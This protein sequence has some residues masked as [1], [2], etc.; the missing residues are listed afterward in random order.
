MATHEIPTHLEVQDKLVFG[1]TARQA[2]AIG[3]GLC[4]GYVIYQQTHIRLLGYGPWA[5]PLVMRI[6]SGI[7]GAGLGVL[8]AFVRPLNRPLETWVLVYVRYAT[9]PKCTR[10][11]PVLGGHPS[12]DDAELSAL[13]VD[14][15]GPVDEECAPPQSAWVGH[16]AATYAEVLAGD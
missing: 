6:S 7:F 5:V 10:W 14:L 2:L 4:L 15:A 13:I 9:M 8:V 12:A 11:R 3:L 1:L 16:R